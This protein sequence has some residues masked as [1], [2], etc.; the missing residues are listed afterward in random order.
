[1][2]LDHPGRHLV[3]FIALQ[4]LVVVD[5]LASIICKFYI[6]RLRLETVGWIRM[7]LGT[8]VGLASAPAIL[9]DGNTALHFSAHFALARSPILATAE[10]LLVL[11]TDHFS[12]PRSAIGALCACLCVYSCD[13]FQMKRPLT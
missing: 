5:T 13:K 9:L 12:G 7:P 6:S 3:V 10:P 4:N 11:F 2:C 1:M 8:E